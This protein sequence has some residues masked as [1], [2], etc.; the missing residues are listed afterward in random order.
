MSIL[1]SLGETISQWNNP[2]CDPRTRRTTLL[3]IIA[4][5]ALFRVTM[6]FV[7]YPHQ[8]HADE[9]NVIEPAIDMIERNSYLS[10][11]LIHI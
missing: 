10:L 2:F 4:L 8:L 3:I 7:G 5:G 1:R 6:C 11:S 9:M